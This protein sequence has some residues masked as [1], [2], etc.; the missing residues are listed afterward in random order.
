MLW[1]LQEGCEYLF[2][3]TIDGRLNLRDAY[4]MDFAT[5]I[6]AQPSIDEGVPEEPDLYHEI[7]W[8]QRYEGDRMMLKDPWEKVGPG[9]T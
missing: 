1:S 3:V 2:G 4:V 6:Y 9:V 8:A 5:G 7:P